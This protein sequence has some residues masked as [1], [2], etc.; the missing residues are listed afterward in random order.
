MSS[1]NRVYVA[2]CLPISVNLVFSLIHLMTVDKFTLGLFPFPQNG[3]PSLY[4]SWWLTLC[5][6]LSQVFEGSKISDT[7]ASKIS[8]TYLT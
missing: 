2:F 3:K 4:I 1:F 5:V 6:C 8:H 7:T